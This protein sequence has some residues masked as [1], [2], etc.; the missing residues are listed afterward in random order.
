MLTL[1]QYLSTL[2]TRFTPT[3]DYAETETETETE[4]SPKLVYLNNIDMGIASKMLNILSNQISSNSHN[5]NQLW[6]QD[7]LS[8]NIKIHDFLDLNALLISKRN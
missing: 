5:S 7:Q 1:S 3:C 8:D 2:T 6:Y 4:S